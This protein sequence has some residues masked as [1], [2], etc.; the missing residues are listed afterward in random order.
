MNKLGSHAIVVGA[1][2]GGLIAARVLAD[3][4]DRVTI[5]ERDTLP[6]EPECRKGVPHGRHAHGLLARGREVLEAMF[7]GLTDELV[8]AGAVAGDTLGDSRWFNFGVYLAN[9][10]SGLRSILLSRPLLETHLRRR[11]IADH[12]VSIR[13]RSSVQALDVDVNRRRVVGVHL[14][15]APAPEG[16]SLTADLVVDASGRHSHSPEWLERLGYQAPTEETVDVRISYA[17]RFLRRRPHQLGGRRVALIGADE[18]V[19]RFGVALAVEQDRWIVTLGGYFDDMPE[20][21]DAAYLGFARTLAAPDIGELLATAEP[22]TAPV[23]FCFPASRRTHYE[24][25][26][27]FPEG[28]LVFGDA[29]CSFNPV[30]GQGMT[31]AALEGVAFR[32]CLADGAHSLAPRFFAKASNILDTPWQIAVGNDLRHPRLSHHQSMLG[33]FLNWYIGRVHRA[34][35]VDPTIA[36]A[37]LRVANLI[38]PPSKLF[39][40]STLFGVVRGNLLRAGSHSTVA[41]SMTNR[42]AETIN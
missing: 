33:A 22:L 41:A 24:R 5:L 38:E 21:N 7:L 9:G 4:F 12:H 26:K 39:A 10:Q 8:D 19:W 20:A 40:G 32:D 35:A 34:G 3:Y 37:F 23:G 17:T 1:G 18:P 6:A 28:H 42:T 15:S 30:Y 36:S 27:S 13:E 31:A 2:V 14:A 11:L 25:L 29:L 16:E